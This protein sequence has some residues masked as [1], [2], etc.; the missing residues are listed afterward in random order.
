M[1]PAKRRF[2]KF[3]MI[4]RKT[5][6]HQSWICFLTMSRAPQLYVP[7]GIYHAMSRAHGGQ[8]L[9]QDERDR[10]CFIRILKEAC[11]R[12]GVDV[13]ADCQMA[14]HYHL[15]P[16]TPRANISEFMAYLNG[17]FAKYWNRRHRRSGYVFNE[18]YKPL[19][20][21][22]GHYLRVLMSY[23]FNNPVVGGHVKHPAEWPWS[24]YRATTGAEDPPGY[25]CLDWLDTT[26][27]GSSRHE[28]QTLFERYV[29]APS[30]QEAEICFERAIYGGADFKRRIRAHIAATLYTAAIPRAYRALDRPPLDELV[31]TTFDK[32]ERDSA[33]LRAHSV[34]AYTDSEI[35]RYLR[36]HPASVSRII[37]SLRARLIAE[38][39]F[40]GESGTR[41]T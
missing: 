35:G 39:D 10:R 6:R 11:E 13:L 23:V 33:I 31:P 12:C 19:L 2:H 36:L 37:C 1:R 29:T 9:F 3:R 18:R 17:E 20:V 15:V 16:R 22:S 41:S 8:I 7:N 40:E 28:S 4:S 32:K 24:S 34:Y 27:P 26:F 14:T 25:L 5:R 21:D 38:A 30:C